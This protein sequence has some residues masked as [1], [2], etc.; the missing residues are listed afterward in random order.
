MVRPLP[1]RRL[2]V[3]AVPCLLAGCF[4]EPTE[5]TAA[6]DDDPDAEGTDDDPADDG[7]SDEDSSDDDPA[8]N[9]TVETEEP[10]DRVDPENAGIVVTEV[11]ITAVEHGGYWA[12]VSADVTVENVDRF[13]YGFL[14]FR[15]DAYTTTPNSREREPVGFE[16]V[17]RRFPSDD[18]FASGRR[19][20]SLEIRFR[21]RD[22]SLRANSE[23]YDVD[24]TV[25]RAEPSGVDE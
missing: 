18:R 10:P 4:E 1:R 23:W 13:V 20:F 9:G 5:S 22:A 6:T 8:E 16:Y 2:L 12:T 19:Q 14:E 7:G 24:A 17:S 11:E 21:A 15:A 25:R 3:A